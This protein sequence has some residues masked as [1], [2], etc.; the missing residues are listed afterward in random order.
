MTS[1]NYLN[2]INSIN[3]FGHEE[4]FKNL[5][6]IYNLRK[7][8]KV[9][10]LSG[11]K[12]IGK[13]TLANHLIHFIFDK[14]NYDIKK[15]AIDKNSSF[16][17]NIVLNNCDNVINFQNNDFNNIKIDQ[18]RNLKKIIQKTNLNNESR[19]IILDDVELLNLNAANA[20]LKIIEEPSKSNYFILIDNK[21]KALIETVSS[22][23]LI[24]KFFLSKI[25]RS[26][27]IKSLISLYNI[28]SIID[29]VNS[30]ISPG[31]FLK[32]NNF[33]LENAVPVKSHYFLIIEELFFLY[34]KT[35]NKVFINMSIFFT[36]QFFYIMSKK[37]INEIQKINKIKIETIRYINDFFVYNL[38]S[39]SVLHTIRS[40]FK[41]GR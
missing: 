35:K 33:C 14:N 27:I 12:G 7:F 23:C 20:L 31:L 5:V 24:Q 16:H 13:F 39:S 17:K 29:Y 18:V 10:L 2:P 21:Q 4:I 28:E 40:Q 41:D 9:L 15:N 30:D 3:L 19:F 8:P 34:K 11:N 25:E 6:S 36:D 37:K 32:Y 22:R 1:N 38:N 26:K